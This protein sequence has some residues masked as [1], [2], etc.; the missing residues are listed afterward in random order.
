MA[1]SDVLR[2]D[3]QVHQLLLVLSGR[4]VRRIELLVVQHL[5]QPLDR[6]L[7]TPGACEEEDCCLDDDMEGMKERA[8]GTMSVC[9]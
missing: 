2:E 5:P 6:M 8:C 3:E 4:L 1:A 7:I 9:M